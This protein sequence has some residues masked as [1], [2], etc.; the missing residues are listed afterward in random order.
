M[1]IGIFGAGALGSLLG[2][3]LSKK[4]DVT[5]YGRQN[6]I[7]KISS[8][9]LKILGINGEKEYELRAVSELSDEHFDLGI[10]GVKTYDTDNLLNYLKNNRIKFDLVASIQNGLKDDKLISSFGLERVLGCVV[11]EAAKMTAPGEIYYS[12]KGATYFGIFKEEN[13]TIKQ[14]MAEDLTSVLNDCG[15]LT[16]VSNDLETLTWYKFMNCVSGFAVSGALNYNAV[17]LFN[18]DFALEL[19]LDSLEEIKTVS[20][21]ENILLGDHPDRKSVV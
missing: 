12:N 7:E 9:A 6:H 8:T 4:H 15:L 16:G 10:V 20:L 17:E 18:N 13:N 11:N 2:A 14:E 1:K 19:L 21:A 5:L 3:Y